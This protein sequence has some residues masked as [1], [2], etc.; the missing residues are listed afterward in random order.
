MSRIER[1]DWQQRVST[2]RNRS[3]W[4]RLLKGQA[5]WNNGV[6][7]EIVKPYSSLGRRRGSNLVDVLPP[8]LPFRLNPET[9]KRCNFKC[10]TCTPSF[11]RKSTLGGIVTMSL[12]LH[13]KIVQDILDLGRRAKLR[14]LKLCQESEP[15]IDPHLSP[16]QVDSNP[17][18]G[19]KVPP[20]YCSN[21][22]PSALGT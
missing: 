7:V 18:I 9:A 17:S 4:E 14:S 2:Q 16:R 20:I 8:P 11:K 19:L 13:R 10:T 22:C 5:V 6:A 12:D 15:F 21:L 1:K 3:T